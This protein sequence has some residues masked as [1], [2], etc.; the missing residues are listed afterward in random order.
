MA[1]EASI[2]P[3]VDINL[4]GQLKV[5]G[6]WHPFGQ[7]WL[8]IEQLAIVL[9][10]GTTLDQN[11]K[12][13]LGLGGAI[14]LGTPPDKLDLEASFL[15]GV[16]TLQYFPWVTANI[17]GIR[18]QT[19]RGLRSQDLVTLADFFSES[20]TNALEIPAEVKDAVVANLPEIDIRDV[21]ISFSKVDNVPLCLRKGFTIKGYLYVNPTSTP[22]YVQ[23]P[24][25]DPSPPPTCEGAEGCLGGIDIEVVLTAAQ[26]PKI[27]GQFDLE[28]FKIGEPISIGPANIDLE[29]SQESVHLKLHGEMEIKN[30][31]SGLVDLKFTPN[32]YELKAEAKLFDAFW[33]YL[34]ANLT[35]VPP[36]FQ[37]H[38]ELKSE[39]GTQIASAL[40]GETR[41]LRALLATLDQLYRDF[42]DPNKDLDDLTDSLINLAPTLQQNG[43]S[44][45]MITLMATFAAQVQ[46]A[47]ATAAAAGMYPSLDPIGNTVLQGAPI[48][49]TQGNPNG[50]WIYPVC[51]GY[52]SKFWETC[53]GVWIPPS[54]TCFTYWDGS[55]CWLVPP[56]TLTIPGICP[57][58]VNV[59]NCDSKGLKKAAAQAV[60]EGFEAIFGVPLSSVLHDLASDDLPVLF[61]LNC[62]AF[63]VDLGSQADNTV[64]LFL[65]ITL[66]G[67]P[68]VWEGNWDFD[69]SLADNI[70]G[71]RE[72]LMAFIRNILGGGPPPDPY[73]ECTHTSAPPLGG[74]LG[75]PTNLTISA[76]ASITEGIGFT[77]HG[78]FTEDG[79][80]PGD[81]RTYTITWGD[82]K[83]TT[84]TLAAGKTSFDVPYTYEIG[85][86]HV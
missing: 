66:L 3:T 57:A 34:D 52:Y 27:K 10:V 12:I 69:A 2:G 5:A 62:A 4:S 77:L 1:A 67:K 54:T 68:V 71:N 82:G 55:T 36:S 74:N 60:E 79:V 29:I 64:D 6:E 35:I 45:P 38:G 25:C 33:A 14:V 83:T 8:T 17:D 49:T 43:A 85:R 80:Q 20:V 65:G 73:K 44:G 51:V 86:A 32:S 56:I 41:N 70:G 81:V 13:G 47:K 7:E 18:F 22:D 16:K 23:R 30:V 50:Y 9:N 76:P 42:Q 21:E 48:T 58:I 37:A 40:E 59:E 46:Q 26:P 39:F 75:T 19:D 84:A 72:F 24:P 53:Y 15:I 61:D 63:D 31:G 78:A 28:K 11:V